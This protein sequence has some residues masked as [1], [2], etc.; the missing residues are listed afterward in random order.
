MQTVAPAEDSTVGV[1]AAK[2]SVSRV[3]LQLDAS[4]SALVARSLLLQIYGMLLWHYGRNDNRFSHT[5]PH[6]LSQLQT[7]AVAFHT[8]VIVARR[9]Q[10]PQVK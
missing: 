9:P 5:K 7:V 3:L 4:C 8:L 10:L 2:A 1:S 6:P